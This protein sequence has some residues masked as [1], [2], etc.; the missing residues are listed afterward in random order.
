M[1]TFAVFLGEL[2]GKLGDV[3]AIS[4]NLVN[5]LDTEFSLF[6]SS[7]NVGAERRHFWHIYSSYLFSAN[8]VKSSDPGHSRSGHQNTSS[9]LTSEKV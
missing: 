5:M 2:P 9:D 4:C 7:F 8:V 3:D 1:L 6:G